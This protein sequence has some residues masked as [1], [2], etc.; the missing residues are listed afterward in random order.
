MDPWS[1]GK[2]VCSDMTYPIKRKQSQLDLI[3]GNSYWKK[4]NLQIGSSK[5]KTVKITVTLFLVFFV[6]YILISKFISYQVRKK[7]ASESSERLDKTYYWAPSPVS[8]S[9]LSSVG[10]ANLNFEQFT[11]QDHTLRATYVFLLSSIFRQV[12]ENVLMQVRQNTNPSISDSVKYCMKL[13][14]NNLLNICN[15]YN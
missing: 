5:E 2:L 1:Q 12:C 4:E 11:R 7:F 9:R 15:Y 14:D 10:P 13:F 6:F 3:I 8:D